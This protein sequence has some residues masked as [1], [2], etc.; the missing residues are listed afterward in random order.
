MALLAVH[1]TSS[2][3]GVLQHQHTNR[4]CSFRHLLS[5]S[6]MTPHMT[7]QQLSTGKNHIMITQAQADL[8]VAHSSVSFLPHPPHLSHAHLLDTGHQERQPTYLQQAPTSQFFRTEV[9]QQCIAK[10]SLNSLRFQPAAGGWADGGWT[11]GR[12][13]VTKATKSMAHDV[14]KYI[15]Y[16]TES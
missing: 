4:S 7:P 3:G 12:R 14:E 2:V 8:L 13:M 11:D 16:F 6:N 15:S 5:N 9:R 1:T 10:D